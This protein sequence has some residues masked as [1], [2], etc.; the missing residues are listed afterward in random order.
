M[1]RVTIE[2]LPYGS[3]EDAEVLG[4]FDIINDMTNTQRPDYGNYRV[5]EAMPYEPTN[6]L[7]IRIRGHKRDNGWLPLV[8]TV[9]KKLYELEE[10]TK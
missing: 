7:P 3:V 2:L 9:F 10:K 5:E 4:R 6:C 8:F 1:L